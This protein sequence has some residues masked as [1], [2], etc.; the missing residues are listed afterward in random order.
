VSGYDAIAPVYDDWSAHMS[1]DVD[2]YVSL[3]AEAA[4]PVVELAV[5]N[6]RV[7]VPIAERTGRRVIGIDD[8]QAMLERA[9]A[10]A[11]AAG[12]ELDLRHGDMRELTLD[13]PTD[14]VICP[15]RS[16]LHLPTWADRRRVFERVAEALVPGGRFAWNSF[17]F[18]PL[19][20]AEH[21]GR[22]EEQ[23]GVLHRVDH[24]PADSRIDITIADRGTISLHW[25]TR[26]EW[27]G[28]VEVAGLEVEALHGWFDRRPLD[29]ESRELVYVARR[30][31]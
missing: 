26:S 25:V 9:R 31:A 20:A 27:D 24:V 7:A 23:N 3:A 6:G 19:V 22:W 1:E 17:A 18:D 13:E 30:P 21:A 29:D 4:G 10:R 2:F 28:L 15:F 14:L 8:S 16:L 12:V 5:G 11:E